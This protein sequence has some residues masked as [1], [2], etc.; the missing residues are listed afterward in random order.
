MSPC[1]SVSHLIYLERLV[2]LNFLRQAYFRAA[3]I[4]LGL[5]EGSSVWTVFHVG[6]KPDASPWVNVLPKVEKKKST[7][8][9]HMISVANSRQYCCLFAVTGLNH[10]G[11]TVVSHGQ[12]PPAKA[13]APKP[14]IAPRCTYCTVSSIILLPLPLIFK[15]FTLVLVFNFV[16]SSISFQGSNRTELTSYIPFALYPEG[17]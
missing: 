6:L 1:T 15:Y 14:K 2:C 3:K 10:R 4:S 7:D 8:F 11:N 12:Y 5:N 17:W 13:K 16:V 9:C